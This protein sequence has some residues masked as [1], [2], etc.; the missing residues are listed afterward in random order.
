MQPE[1]SDEHDGSGLEHQ[2][3]VL[4]RLGDDSSV[5]AEVGGEVGRFVGLLV[6]CA[7]G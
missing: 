5:G 6:G 7:D 1:A 4:P 2:T 3:L